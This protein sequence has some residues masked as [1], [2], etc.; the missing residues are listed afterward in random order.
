MKIELFLKNME[1]LSRDQV[2]ITKNTFLNLDEGL[3]KERP[4][5]NKWSITEC[6]DHLNLTLEIYIPQ[7]IKVIEHPEKYTPPT[8]EFKHSLL[9]KLAVYAME[10]KKDKT[11]RF[12][13]KT[14]KNL[15]PQDTVVDTKN[16]LNDFLNYQDKT[17]RIIHGL[18]K[19]NPA[20]PKIITA[21]G[22]VLKMR[23]GDALH[24][25]LAH[26]QRH[27]IQAQNVLQKIR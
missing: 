5:E 15:E 6:F 14:F 12:K 10:P 17:I 4:L 3:L 1:A 27:L 19:I 2:S 24:F 21:V 18:R 20:K 23:M 11:F 8:E 7:M 16:V 13:M 25:M 9:G 26:N 22:P